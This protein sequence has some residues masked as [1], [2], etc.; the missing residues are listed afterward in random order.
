[1]EEECGY[2][3]GHGQE[4]LFPPHSKCDAANPP[5]GCVKALRGCTLVCSQGLQLTGDT[6]E[7]TFAA[8]QIRPP[9]T[10][11]NETGR[12]PVRGLLH[13]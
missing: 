2:G 6:Q 11:S 10:E 1:M 12:G 8:R 13:R 7:E 9:A 3:H 5:G 4:D